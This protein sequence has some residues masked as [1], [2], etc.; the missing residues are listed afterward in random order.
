[1]ISYLE[2]HPQQ[3]AAADKF[4]N[5]YQESAVSLVKQYIE[6]EQS[7][8][9]S[10]HATETKRNTLKTLRDFQQAYQ[11]QFDKMMNDHLMYMDAEISVAQY[12]MKEDGI[13]NFSWELLEECPRADLNEKERFKK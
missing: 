10:P 7:G 12:A 1:M 5:Y 13:W 6:L 3:I 8:L 4:I 2:K 9:D 11:E